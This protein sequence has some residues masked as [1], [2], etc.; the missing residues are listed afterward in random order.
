[1]AILPKDNT[2]SLETQ[3]KLLGKEKTFYGRLLTFLGNF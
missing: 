3:T 2:I 1:M